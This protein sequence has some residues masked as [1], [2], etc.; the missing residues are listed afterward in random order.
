MMKKIFIFLLMLLFHVNLH[1][2]QA[3]G[4]IK[5]PSH[6][7]GNNISKKSKGGEIKRGVSTE[8]TSQRVKHQINKGKDND[9]IIEEKYINMALYSLEQK[10]N[11]GDSMAQ[12]FLGYKYAQNNSYEKAVNWFQKAAYKD[13]P[14]AQ[15]WLAYCYLYGKGVEKNTLIARHWIRMAADNGNKDA[16]EYLKTWFKD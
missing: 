12:F 5:R 1:A 16:K 6:N 2:Q 15:I 4:V 7:T 13:L 9:E 3:G 8:K 11:E 14:R 10:A